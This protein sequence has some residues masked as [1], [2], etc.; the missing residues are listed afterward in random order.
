MK[1]VMTHQ[2]SQIPKV[3]IQRSAFD[4]SHGFK[5]T[6]DEGKLIPILVDEAL[7]GDTFRLKDS[8]LIRMSTPIYPIMDNL[9][10]DV[11]YFSVPLRLVWDDFVKFMGE[12]KNPSDSIDYLVPTVA[13]TLGDLEN[14]AIDK[15]G[16]Y[17]VGSL[18]DYMGLPVGGLG[19]ASSKKE[20]QLPPIS[21]LFFR[22]YWLI[23]NE[24]YRDENLQ[25]SVNVCLDSTNNVFV[26][27][28]TN[29]YHWYNLAPRGKRHDYFTSCLP[30]PQKGPAVDLPLGESAPIRY[31]TSNI[32]GQSLNSYFDS[33]M[34]G[35]GLVGT[36]MT[37]SSGT[38]T[39]PSP[40]NYISNTFSGGLR[41]DTPQKDSTNLF[42]Y[43]VDYQIP[44]STVSP[45]GSTYTNYV[46]PLI[47]DLSEVNAVTINSLRQA[48]AIQHLLELDA[49]GGTR[50]IELILTHFGVQSPDYR[51]Q[52]PEYLGGHT[53]TI[54]TIPVPQTSASVEDVSPQGNLS[55]YTVG[56]DTSKG[57]TASFT[58]HCIVIGLMSVRADLTY[59]QGINRMWSRQTRYDFYWPSL[60][61]I[62]EQAVL[63]KEIFAQGTDVDDEVFGYQERYAEYRYFP[64]LVTGKMRTELKGGD[65]SSWNLSQ[66]FDNVPQLGSQFIVENPPIDRVVAVQDEPHFILDSFFHMKCYR[67]MP[68]YGTPGLRKM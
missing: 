56:S 45:A 58:E 59:Q 10:C 61:H 34:N 55:A 68:V 4:R 17:G 54:N 33:N 8:F 23:W 51:L 67:P 6:F 14:P 11:Q 22:A 20:W 38:T 15:I 36:A 49:R 46:Y 63:N 48:F 39:A 29:D 5:T 42:A 47:A 26:P 40:L 60:A 64:S 66:Y 44:V 12:R 16:A 62:G 32:A 65:L 41:V 1:S 50:Y 30:W 53:F 28:T 3:N 27:D 31:S 13:P 18:L 24:W 37:A 7:P 43:G 9:R 52:R 25:D 35:V 2:F 19:K 21:A 57:F